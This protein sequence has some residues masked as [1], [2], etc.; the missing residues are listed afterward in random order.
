MAKQTRLLLYSLV[1]LVALLAASTTFLFFNGRTTK[2]DETKVPAETKTADSS[3]TGVLSGSPLND[4]NSTVTKATSANERPSHPT[5]TYTIQQGET[6]FAIA[7]KNGTTLTDLSAANGITDKDKVQA[8]QV[9]II[10]R[11]GQVAYTIDNSKSTTLQTAVETGKNQ[12]RLSP[13][14][15]ARADGPNVYGLKITDTYTQ[16]SKDTNSGK[17]EVIAENENG[18]YLIKLIQPITKGDKGIWV[19]EMI[20]P[21]Q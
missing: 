15:T 16:K 14:D 10:P 5:D 6:L 3:S 7:Q 9:L 20:I 12:F 11:N 21:A 1:F 18:K 13:E 17:A 4:N 2:N 8:G 19:I